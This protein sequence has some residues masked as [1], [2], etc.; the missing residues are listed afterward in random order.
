MFFLVMENQRR[1][2]D[3]RRSLIPWPLGWFSATKPSFPINTG[4]MAA[5]LH[6]ASASY[7]AA[8]QISEAMNRAGISSE[9]RARALSFPA[10]F[11]EMQHSESADNALEAVF[12]NDATKLAAFLTGNMSRSERAQYAS[13]IRQKA[14][15]LSKEGDTTTAAQLEHMADYS[16]ITAELDAKNAAIGA[17]HGTMVAASQSFSSLFS[18]LVGAPSHILANV[19][20]DTIR[21]GNSEDTVAANQSDPGIVDMAKAGATGLATAAV[22]IMTKSGAGR[23]IRA[24]GQGIG[25]RI[26][27]SNLPEQVK[28]IGT[29]IF[30]KP[31]SKPASV[32]SRRS[33]EDVHTPEGKG[34]PVKTEETTANKG[35]PVDSGDSGKPGDSSGPGRPD[36]SEDGKGLTRKEFEDDNDFDD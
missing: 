24:A 21:S 32:G 31:K 30:G 8:Q 34:R 2:K 27:G 4:I 3:Y 5:R 23:V 25:A 16:D 14:A 33:N 26:E 35:R 36:S 1:E 11:N 9:D 6:A 19:Q 20:S 12:G 17:G 10:V 13:S 28:T 22:L 15:E 7:A 18:H 29:A